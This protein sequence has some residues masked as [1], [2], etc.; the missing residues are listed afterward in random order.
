MPPRAIVRVRFVHGE[1]FSSV[2]AT[3]H[4]GLAWMVEG[5]VDTGLPPDSAFPC[6]ASLAER[7]PSFDVVYGDA[8]DAVE[9]L[10]RL[11]R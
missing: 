6:L 5:H 9:R 7:V 8:A 4:E 11:D 2:Q 10:T 1:R 3:A